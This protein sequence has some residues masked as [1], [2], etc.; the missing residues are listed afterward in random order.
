MPHNPEEG[1]SRPAALPKLIAVVLALLCCQSVLASSHYHITKHKR[2]STIPETTRRQI[3]WEIATAEDRAQR[4]AEE[5]YPTSLQGNVDESQADANVK[6]NGDLAN[7]LT[8]RY[9]NRIKRRYH[10]TDKQ[11]TDII[12]EAVQKNWPTP[13]PTKD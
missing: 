1:R 11:F 9:H 12:G 4:E 6:P 3:A 2:V 10:L 5:R 13:D 8:D 7:I